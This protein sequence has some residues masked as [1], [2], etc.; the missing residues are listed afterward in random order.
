MIIE[1]GVQ[2]GAHIN[3]GNFYV[4]PLNLTP[5]PYVTAGLQMFWDMG[6]TASYPGSGATATDFSA[7]KFY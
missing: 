5:S 7:T 2:I 6:D 4:A 1:S 3:L